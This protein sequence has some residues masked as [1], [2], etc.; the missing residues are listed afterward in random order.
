MMKRLFFILIVASLVACG[1]E[2]DIPPSVKESFQSKYPTAEDVDW[3]TEDNFYEA[4]FKI[5]ND[6][7]EALF[8]TT[9]G[10]WIETTQEID[11]EELPVSVKQVLESEMYNG[12]EIDDVYKAETG[13]NPELYKIRVKMG[14]NKEYHYFDSGGNLIK[15][16]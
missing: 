7:Y 2:E 10:I 15:K 1:S 9:G 4:D 14:D 16:S 8:S 3:D 11:Q 12:W 13:D 5:N 6:N